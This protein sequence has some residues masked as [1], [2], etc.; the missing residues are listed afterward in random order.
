MTPFLRFGETNVSVKRWARVTRADETATAGVPRP[1]ASRRF[2]KANLIS[3]RERVVHFYS[4]SAS[5]ATG[6]RHAPRSRRRFTTL[7]VRTH[8]PR[9]SRAP[10]RRR[11]QQTRQHIF[12]PRRHNIDHSP[13][14][15]RLFDIQCRI[16][17]ST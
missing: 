13:H 5:R 15:S 11:P 6:P 16:A 8:R 12:P 14:G 17:K 1:D 10:A 7:H 4:W 3:T 9:G 2:V